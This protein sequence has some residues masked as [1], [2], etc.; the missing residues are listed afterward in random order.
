MKI[1]SMTNP[2]LVENDVIFD[3]NLGDV[4]LS[5]NAIRNILSFSTD[6][7]AGM[8]EREN[9]EP[10][11]NPD[12][13]KAQFLPKINGVGFRCNCGCNVFH[14]PDR[15]IPSIYECNACGIEYET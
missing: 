15:K 7:I 9:V 4:S 12:G 11:L 6:I 2:R 1:D 14:K 5:I 8:S 3:T 13:S 10:V